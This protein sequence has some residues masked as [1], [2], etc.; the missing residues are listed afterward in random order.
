[1]YVNPTVKLIMRLKNYLCDLWGSIQRKK[2]GNLIATWTGHF[3]PNPSSNPNIPQA[4]L[5]FL[6]KWNVVTLLLLFSFNATRGPMSWT[7]IPTL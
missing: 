1:M 6:N 7:E 2:R 5:Y 3:T 4:N